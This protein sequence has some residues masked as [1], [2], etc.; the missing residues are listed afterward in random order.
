MQ[1]FTPSH[2]PRFVAAAIILT[3]GEMFTVLLFFSQ[4]LPRCSNWKLMKWTRNTK[5]TGFMDAYHAPFTPKHR[6]WVGLL[7]FAL[8]VHNTVAA[9]ATDT[10]LPVLSAGSLSVG[11]ITLKLLSNKVYKDWS[12]DCLETIFLLNLAILTNGT[13]YAKG[14]KYSHQTLANISMAMSVTLFMIIICYHSYKY[15]ISNT[16]MWL[17]LTVKLSSLKSNVAEL[18]LRQATNQ[19]QAMYQV[20]ANSPEDTPPAI[21]ADQ[22]REPDLDDLAPITTDDYQPAPHPPRPQ[23]NNRQGVTYAVVE[24]IAAHEEVL[25]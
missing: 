4:W 16:R 15:M 12:K 17:K 11:L 7:L 19:R 10:F 18:R 1:Y 3:A 8:I 23:A 5:Y 24:P 2:I 9:M 6:Y 22:L 14:L 13:F 20:I 21:R 25:V